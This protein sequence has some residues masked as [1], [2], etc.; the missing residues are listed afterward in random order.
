MKRLALLL[1]LIP[2]LARA[3][4]ETTGRVTGY[5]Y[6][7]TGMAVWGATL[8]LH[9]PAMQRPM[10]R[11]SDENGRYV[12]ENVPVGEKY[13]IDVELQGFEPQKLRGI[14]VVLGQTTALDVKLDMPSATTGETYEIKEQ[15]TPAI[16]PE[17]AETGAEIGIEKAT[18]LPLFQQAQGMPQLVAGVGPGNTPS[19][20]GGLSRWGRFYVDGMDTTDVTDGSITAPLNWYAISDFEIITGGFD[21]QYNAMGMVENVV[22]RTGGNEWTYDLSMT[23]SPTFFTAKNQVPG[24]QPAYVQDYNNNT[25]PLP[26]TSFYSPVI[27]VGGP[28]VKDK[29]WFYFSGQMNFSHRETPITT[30]VTPPENR[31]TD[32]LTE[33]TRLK[34]TWQAS[35]KDRVSI[36]FNQDLNQIDNSIGSASVTLAAESRIDRGGYFVILNYDHYFTDN[37]WFSL[38]AG[39]TY[40]HANQDPQSADYTTVSHFDAAQNVTQLNADRIAFNVQGDWLHETKTRL[41]FD[42]TINWLR[43]SHVLKAGVQTSVMLDE[44]STGVAGGTRF[45]DFGGICDPMM[46]ATFGFCSTRTDYYNTNNQKVGGPNDPHLT[47]DASALNLGFF[48]QDKWTVTRKLTLMP[49]FRIDMG[50][51]KDDSGNTITTMTG[52]GPRFGL[53]YDPWG[54]RKG[55]IVAN[56]GRSNDV[57]NILVAQHA[58]ASL[59][60]VIS[61]WQTGTNTFAMCDPTSVMMNPPPVGCST[62]GGKAG[63]V[64]DSSATPPHVDEFALGYHHEA[65][66]GLVLGLDGT[67]RYYANM[68]ADQETNRIWD[69]S[70]QVIVGY[71]NNIPQSIVRSYTPDSAYREY[72]GVDLW[73]QGTKGPWDVLASYTVEY[74]DGTV[75]DYFD[76]FLANPRFTMFYDGQL[77]DD[78]RHTVKGSLSYRSPSGF[79]WGFHLVYRT[80]S[81][82]WESFTNTGDPNLRAYHSPRGTGF[83]TNPATGQPDFNDPTSWVYMRNPSQ[84]LMD[85]QARYDFSRILHTTQRVELVGFI[86][87][88]LNNEDPVT[89]TDSWAVKNN[90]FG[91]ASFR[92]SPFQAEII[93]RVRNF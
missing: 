93:I 49:G 88:V 32:T 54:T 59:L 23:L 47:T 44:Q 68:W 2:S 77:P 60:Q 28:I 78:H 16:N 92:N 84:F 73:A 64:F 79:D 21:A 7:P 62:A 57:G 29:L 36:A 85:V 81:P 58:N 45:T 9:G 50:Q 3:T 12:F 26:E 8:T 86:V 89:L 70:G 76:G 17:S 35:A 66:Q 56:Y 67:Y 25:L 87:N 33:L 37:V 1:L 39:T 46:A 4:G 30:P 10:T 18:M 43:G 82:M 80:G 74:N 20:R 40:K 34:L 15:R 55:L 48:V 27:A 53:S 75:S 69:P 72:F 11:Q 51:L 13:A 6:D 5:V 41:Q 19:S 63:R 42:P 61:K 22:T 24:S 65:V 91:L 31:P 71:K 38:Q 83:A 90:R 52:F 14:K